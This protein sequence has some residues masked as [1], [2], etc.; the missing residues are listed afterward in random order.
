[1]QVSTTGNRASLTARKRCWRLNYNDREKLR[2]LSAM[3]YHMDTTSYQTII[4]ES[5]LTL[6]GKKVVN[7]RTMDASLKLNSIQRHR[8]LQRK[9]KQ[10]LLSPLWAWY[11]V[12]YP[13]SLN[14]RWIHLKRTQSYVMKCGLRQYPFKNSPINDGDK[15]RLKAA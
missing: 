14:L 2:I 7:P 4:E 8:D 10:L 5:L 6:F 15:A 3:L 13:W 1:M 11:L 9:P 12:C